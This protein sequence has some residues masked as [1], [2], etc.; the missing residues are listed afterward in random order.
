MVKH[1]CRLQYDDSSSL[2]V[3]RQE[4]EQRTRRRSRGRPEL[5]PT[6]VWLQSR[7]L[8]RKLLSLMNLECYQ[9]IDGPRL[10]L[11]HFLQR[12]VSFRFSF[13]LLFPFELRTALLVYHR[14]GVGQAYLEKPH[15][16]R[17]DWIWRLLN[18]GVRPH[19]R[20]L[21]CSQ[22]RYSLQLSMFRVS[23]FCSRFSPFFQ[24]G[25]AVSFREFTAG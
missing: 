17:A 24:L 22:S 3:R 19:T 20:F 13:S 12:I 7:I 1:C 4:S 18:R 25:L 2:L 15:G 5:A 8:A 14:P 21:V 10:R 6:K 23:G 16:I 9:K 11:P